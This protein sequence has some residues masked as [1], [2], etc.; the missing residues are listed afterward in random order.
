MT[1]TIIIV[2]VIVAIAFARIS[3]ALWRGKG[4]EQI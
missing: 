3:W 2:I 4:K 1:A